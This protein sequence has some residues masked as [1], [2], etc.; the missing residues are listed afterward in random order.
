MPS[1]GF[2]PCRSRRDACADGRN[3][4]QAPKTAAAA[5]GYRASGEHTSGASG[6][7][8]RSSSTRTLPGPPDLQSLVLN[9]SHWS[10]GTAR[11]VSGQWSVVKSGCW[12]LDA[13]I[14]PSFIEIA[15]GIAIGIGV[16]LLLRHSPV[17][18]ENDDNDKQQNLQNTIP[19]AISIPTP[20]DPSS[21]FL[22]SFS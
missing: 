20:K 17:K 6:P 1:F 5:D 10:L 2:E 22:F 13:G 18:P 14:G 19:I 21:T 8:P 11:T 3:D 16:W 9:Y 12:I 7:L 15:I 4:G